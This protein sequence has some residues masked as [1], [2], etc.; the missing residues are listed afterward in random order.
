MEKF[1][2]LRN[3]TV[4]QGSK[5]IDKEK[6]REKKRFNK[7]QKPRMST[8]MISKDPKYKKNSQVGKVSR[9]RQLYGHD[10]LKS[11]D[12]QLSY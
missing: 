8:S 6:T 10:Q 9:N 7:E 12:S 3:K 11:I 5:K 1:N 2:K 4:P